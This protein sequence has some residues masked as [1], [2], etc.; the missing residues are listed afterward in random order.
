MDLQLEFKMNKFFY[1]GFL[2][3]NLCYI[4]ANAQWAE[5]NVPQGNSSNITQIVADDGNLYAATWGNGIHKSTD[6]GKLDSR[7]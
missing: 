6:G 5:T 4:K 2:L 3:L 1:T 7:K